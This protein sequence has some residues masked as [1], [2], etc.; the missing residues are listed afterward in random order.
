MQ[1]IKKHRAADSQDYFLKI[2]DD[3]KSV[4]FKHIPI[5]ERADLRL[6]A[7]SWRVILDED[8]SFCLSIECSTLLH[9]QL[10]GLKEELSGELTEDQKYQIG[11]IKGLKRCGTLK[12][13]L[14]IKTILEK[15]FPSAQSPADTQ[16]FEFSH[17]ETKYQLYKAL[18]KCFRGYQE[19]EAFQTLIDPNKSPW[20]R[21]SAAH[22]LNKK[23]NPSE[24]D[25]LIYVLNSSMEDYDLVQCAIL[26]SLK[27]NCIVVDD[28]DSMKKIIKCLEN[29]AVKWSQREICDT[30]AL[31]W[32][33][34][35]IGYFSSKKAIN[36]EAIACLNRFYDSDT[37]F[38]KMESAQILARFASAE[39]RTDLG[40]I[41]KN[42]NKD[43]DLRA[44]VALG[45]AARK[46]LTP[47]E[48]EI[49][50]SIFR[51]YKEEKGD[52]E[53]VL[54]KVAYALG[55]QGMLDDLIPVLDSKGHPPEGSFWKTFEEGP[56]FYY[57]FYKEAIRGL[58]KSDSPGVAV[59]LSEL[60]QNCAEDIAVVILARKK[61]VGKWVIAKDITEKDYLESILKGSNNPLKL[62]LAAA[63]GL[64][65]CAHAT[66]EQS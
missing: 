63:K 30:E 46:D 39:K 29:Y 24:V 8:I 1:P 66:W 14:R 35:A 32:A 42:T 56:S 6:V 9:R 43:C 19:E 53:E 12:T 13:G 50:R 55:R 62:R 61:N 7:S 25:S 21:I 17:W 49:L 2:G 38:L 10:D 28:T 22:K 11:I 3:L 45:L 36:E 40:A 48:I 18:G 44:G 64:G 52:D 41:L 33:V 4:V 20:N 34:E 57:R 65:A 5:E 47:T 59:Y 51:T 26:E 60:T 58:C 27:K 16:D 31:S 15:F 23:L 54:Y 37:E